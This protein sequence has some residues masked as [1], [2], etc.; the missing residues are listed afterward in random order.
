MR[1][2]LFAT[3]LRARLKLNLLATI[4][5]PLLW[6][7]APTAAQAQSLQCLPTGQ[8]VN[9]PTTGLDIQPCPQPQTVE[10]VNI[11]SVADPVADP[12]GPPRNNSTVIWGYEASFFAPHVRSYHIGPPV[13]P[14]ANCVPGAPIP[15]ASN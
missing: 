4:C 12:T 6:I 2:N 8:V 10:T 5:I 13:T 11:D 9:G 14:I 15:P 7:A 3:L 1:S